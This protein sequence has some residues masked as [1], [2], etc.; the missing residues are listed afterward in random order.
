VI[1]V[2]ATAR[3][4]LTPRFAKVRSLKLNLPQ[5]FVVRLVLFPLVK[6]IKLFLVRIY[7][8]MRP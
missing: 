7:A 5:R 6:E 8:N 1:K 3:Q 4:D 2:R